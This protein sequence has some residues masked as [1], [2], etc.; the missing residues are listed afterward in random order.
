MR[1]GGILPADKGVGSV[2]A[3][4]A[5]CRS[6]RIHTRPENENVN[7]E[8]KTYK[9]REDK[10]GQFLD[11]PVK[12]ADHAMDAMRYALYTHLGKQRRMFLGKSNRDVRPT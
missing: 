3:G 4:I 7:M 12:F 2:N 11:E 5:F 10:N 6:L 8:N 9:R 1:N